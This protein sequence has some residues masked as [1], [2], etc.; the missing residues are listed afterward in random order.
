M[1][2]P[3]R[4]QRFHEVTRRIKEELKERLCAQNQANKIFDYQ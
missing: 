4:T 1:L 2:K 3:Q